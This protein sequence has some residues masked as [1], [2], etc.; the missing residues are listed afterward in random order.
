LTSAA[1]RLSTAGKFDYAWESF[2]YAHRIG[3]SFDAKSELDAD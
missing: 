1:Y 3:K 2:D